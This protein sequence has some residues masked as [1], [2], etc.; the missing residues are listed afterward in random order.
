MNPK[1]ISGQE[2]E[3]ILR[4]FFT[5][6]DEQIKKMMKDPRVR[7]TVSSPR[8][9]PDITSTFT[10]HLLK[11]IDH[12]RFRD[13]YIKEALSELVRMI[14]KPN[15]ELRKHVNRRFSEIS[16]ELSRARRRHERDYYHARQYYEDE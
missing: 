8:T 5:N 11:F 1:E 3:K 14:D 15:D 6:D 16:S 10:K 2:K 7:V 13:E 9:E 4:K 12:S